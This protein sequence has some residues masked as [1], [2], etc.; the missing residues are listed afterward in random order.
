[1]D[2]R[3]GCK[4]TGPEALPAADP[5]VVIVM[6]RGF[7]GEIAAEARRLAPRADIVFYA[8]LLADARMSQAA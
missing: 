6:S 3:F 4:L 7:A 5:D 2:D 8:D 1:M